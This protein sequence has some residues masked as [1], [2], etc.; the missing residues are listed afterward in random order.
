MGVPAGAQLLLVVLERLDRRLLRV[1]DRVG[2]AGGAAVG[3]AH[4]V[5]VRGLQ[6]RWRMEKVVNV[7]DGG[8]E[9]QPA[10]AQHAAVARVVAHRRAVALARGGLLGGRR[11]EDLDVTATDLLVV[12]LQHLV[13]HGGRGEGDEGLAGG[14]VQ[15]RH[16]LGLQVDAHTREELTHLLA[17]IAPRQPA[18]SRNALFLT[19]RIEDRTGDRLDESAGGRVRDLERGT[20]QDRCVALSK[21]RQTGAHDSG[22]GWNNRGGESG[23]ASRGQ[24]GGRGRRMRPE[25]RRAGT[26]ES[27]SS[28]CAQ[29]RRP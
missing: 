21:T 5:D 6:R 3:L 20:R 27:E 10:H 16:R 1:E 12:G 24:Q 28:C 11:C 19:H 13:Q 29:T 25:A 17:A 15:H 26:A 4:E 8:G 7:L 23:V 9:G 2:I 14:V 22:Q 18:Q